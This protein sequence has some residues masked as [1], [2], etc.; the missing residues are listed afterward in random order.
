MYSVDNFKIHVKTWREIF[1]EFELNHDFLLDKLQMIYGL[2][3]RDMSQKVG[4]T[5]MQTFHI[6]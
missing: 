6:T 5:L 3:E 1:T 4:C 2:L